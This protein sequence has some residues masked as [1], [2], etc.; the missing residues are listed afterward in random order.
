MSNSAVN[1]SVIAKIKDNLDK[2]TKVG[3]EKPLFFSDEQK[4]LAN[5]MCGQIDQDIHNYFLSLIEHVHNPT[6]GLTAEQISNAT[7]DL[8]KIITTIAMIIRRHYNYVIHGN[9]DYG[10]THG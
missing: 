7:Q 8:S 2:I 9:P 10:I 6:A 3:D 5:M 1:D 4:Q